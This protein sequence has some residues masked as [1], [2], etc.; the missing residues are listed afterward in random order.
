MCHIGRILVKFV[1]AM[2]AF[3]FYNLLNNCIEKKGELNDIFRRYK[4]RIFKKKS[5]CGTACRK[6]SEV[7]IL[8]T[9][10][11]LKK[12]WLCKESRIFCVLSAFDSMAIPVHNRAFGGTCF[13]VFFFKTQRGKQRD[14]NRTHGGADDMV[15]CADDIL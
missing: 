12:S 2:A 3:S 4:Q 5:L 11:S 6:K 15:R 9:T 10:E 8:T 13:V 1:I 7:Q 14:C